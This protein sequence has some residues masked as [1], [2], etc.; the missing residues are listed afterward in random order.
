MGRA[1]EVL[2]PNVVVIENVVAVRHDIGRVVYK[3]REALE[4][5]EY[6]VAERVIDLARVA[7][8]AAAAIE[9]RAKE[10]E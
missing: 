7:Q 4:N 6:T 10:V 2:A 9:K 5:A 3:T 8:N 1:A